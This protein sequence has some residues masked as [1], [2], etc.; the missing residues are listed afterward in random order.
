MKPVLCGE[1]W[2]GEA[3]APTTKLFR[4]VKKWSCGT[5]EQRGAWL[6]QPLIRQ[7]RV[8]VTL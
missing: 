4:D 8:S 6:V 7:L 1:R 5:A 2:S 3:L